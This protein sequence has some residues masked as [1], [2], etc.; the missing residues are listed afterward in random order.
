[1][2]SV[3]DS[4]LDISLIT[5]G[6]T[7]AAVDDVDIPGLLRDG[8]DGLHMRS[9]DRAQIQINTNTKYTCDTGQSRNKLLAHGE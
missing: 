4:L 1:M 9:C 6:E 2:R 8:S 7:A 3:M 5:Q